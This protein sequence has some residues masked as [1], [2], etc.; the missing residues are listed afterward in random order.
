MSK[1]LEVSNNLIAEDLYVADAPSAFQHEAPAPLLVPVAALQPV[2]ETSAT[3]AWLKRCL[4]I[5]GACVGV[6]VLGPIMLV[7]M[8]AVWIEDGG[9]VL[10]RQQRVGLNGKRF[11]MIK[12]R[13]MVR[14]AEERLEEVKA[15]NVHDD[16]RTFKAVNDPRVLRS[17]AFLRRFSIDEF[18]QVFNVLKGEM[19]LVGP[20]PSLVHEV[21]MYA[22]EDHVRFEVKPGLTCF[23]QIAGRGEIAFDGQLALDKRYI[24]QQSM[25]TDLS[26][27]ARTVPAMIRGD[28]AR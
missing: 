9:P 13:S 25:L 1:T 4:D 5:C 14:N 28:G 12:I 2:R 23:W 3:Y 10:F 8:M 18:P 6:L 15:L 11:T 16:D 26:I 17:G 27:I 7:A 22:P 20:R 24:D 19:S 21:E